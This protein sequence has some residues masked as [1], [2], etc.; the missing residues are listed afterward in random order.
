[1][2][3]GEI[4][5]ISVRSGKST[6]P[7]YITE[8]GRKEKGANP[9]KFFKGGRNGFPTKRTKLDLIGINSSFRAIERQ[10]N[11]EGRWHG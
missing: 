5:V 6:V 2:K 7:M 3:L 1:V 4:I 10:R 8:Y 9:S 11:S